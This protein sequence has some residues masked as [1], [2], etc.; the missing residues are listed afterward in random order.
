M[1]VHC[2]RPLLCV[3]PEYLRH[4]VS[5]ILNVLSTPI[6]PYRQFSKILFWRGSHVTDAFMHQHRTL[7]VGPWRFIS[8]SICPSN[9]FER[10][11]RFTSPSKRA[12]SLQNFSRHSNTDAPVYLHQWA[13]S[14]ALRS[15]SSE[16]EKKLSNRLA[17]SGSFQSIQNF[18]PVDL[19]SPT[20]L[21]D[22]PTDLTDLW[23]DLWW[24]VSHA[25]PGGRVKYSNETQLRW[26]GQWPSTCKNHPG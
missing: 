13:V 26:P 20:D 22:I 24:L 2:V 12:A 10:H 25:L 17:S 5:G 7:V 16:R 3:R 9:P 6:I 11:R 23:A 1:Q 18:R 14:P 21:S 15:R 8:G 19:R 4:P